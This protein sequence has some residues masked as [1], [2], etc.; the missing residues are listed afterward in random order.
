MAVPDLPNLGPKSRQMLE[1]AGIS[2]L[3]QLRALGSVGAFAR[4]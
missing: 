4:V 1:R 2:S 3:E